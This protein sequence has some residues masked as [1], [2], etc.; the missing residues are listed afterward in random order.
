VLIKIYIEDGPG[1][2]QSIAESF[3]GRSIPPQ[4]KAIQGHK[5]L[6]LKTGKTFKLE[7]DDQVFLV[8]PTIGR[9]APVVS[10]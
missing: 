9:R 6:C 4:V 5:A 7:K 1:R 10:S 8:P 2:K 3:Q